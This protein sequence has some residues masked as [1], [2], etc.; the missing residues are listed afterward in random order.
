MELLHL[1]ILLLIANI[2]HD[3]PFSV[4]AASC[5]PSKF[6]AIEYSCF[7]PTKEEYFLREK[8]ELQNVEV[9][10][11]AKT[12]RLIVLYTKFDARSLESYL[13]LYLAWGKMEKIK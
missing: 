2:C 9:L 11:V 3:C 10:K 1:M 8:K 4:I 6:C 7:I 13:L 12:L 5:I